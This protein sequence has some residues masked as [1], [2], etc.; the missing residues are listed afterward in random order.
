MTRKAVAGIGEYVP[1]LFPT[2]APRNECRRLQ[3]GINPIRTVPM[4]LTIGFAF[5]LNWIRRYGTDCAYELRADARTREPTRARGLMQLI[6]MGRN[7]GRRDARTVAVVRNGRRVTMMSTMTRLR[8]LKG[9]FAVAMVL[10]G[11]AVAVGC[12]LNLG[13]FTG[14]GICTDVRYWVEPRILCKGEEF[15]CSWILVDAPALPTSS[16]TTWTST[17]GDVF[18]NLDNPDR[19][20]NPSTDTQEGYTPR[21]VTGEALRD[22]DVELT[23]RRTY[24]EG[25]SS[26][27]TYPPVRVKVLEPLTD[28]GS[29]VDEVL[30]FE[31][32]CQTRTF[33]DW[34]ARRGQVASRSIQIRTITNSSTEPIVLTISRTYVINEP[35]EINE[36]PLGAFESTRQVEGEFFGTWGIRLADGTDFV[37]AVC[38][39]S[40][41]PGGDVVP[42]PG[43]PPVIGGADPTIEVTVTL[44]CG[45]TDEP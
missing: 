28:G 41:G 18:R 33:E 14:A 38:G 45:S 1:L 12:T 36:I 43:E 22:M 10:A 37:D 29:T 44:E 13:G 25:G 4:P 11:G 17:G 40:G 39:E 5:R 7:S 2:R 24:A 6:A 26:L 9:S 21:T 19:M 35:P 31:F 30:A 34:S 27:C 8:R 23:L 42:G 15:I 20:E 3:M 16:T 32:D